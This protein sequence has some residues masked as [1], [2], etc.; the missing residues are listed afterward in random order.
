MSYAE[1]RMESVELV[2]FL[3]YTVGNQKA[4]MGTQ[5]ATVVQ[6]TLIFLV[7]AYLDQLTISQ[8]LVVTYKNCNLS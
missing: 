6:L 8:L 1:K 5:F 2:E 3:E 7:F 4:D